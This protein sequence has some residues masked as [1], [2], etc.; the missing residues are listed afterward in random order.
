MLDLSLLI[1]TKRTLA[2][3]LITY[4][5][6]HALTSHYY[7]C[8]QRNAE[9]AYLVP[10]GF[11]KARHQHALFFLLNVLGSQVTNSLPE[12]LP[13]RTGYGTDCFNDSLMSE[14]AQYESLFS[15]LR[16]T[17]KLH[18]RTTKITIDV[19]VSI[20]SWMETIGFNVLS[21]V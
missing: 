5:V 20:K 1:K 18:R 21:K 13:H 16:K 19:L 9:A 12:Y 3:L 14:V 17:L 2:L 11:Q 8:R 6:T 15:R 10:R 4:T 7:C